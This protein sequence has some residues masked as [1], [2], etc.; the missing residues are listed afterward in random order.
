MIKYVFI[1]LF[2]P[3]ISFSQDCDLFSNENCLVNK[4]NYYFFEKIII[5]DDCDDYKLDNKERLN[6][7]NDLSQ[8]IISFIKN[9]SSLALSYKKDN[10]EFSDTK[11]FNSLSQ[12]NS[13]AILFNPR[14]LPCLLYTSDAADE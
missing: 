8:S 4:D 2:I 12:S 5:D 11:I 7:K 9:K 10:K 3:L 14:F 1:S 13:S 6:L